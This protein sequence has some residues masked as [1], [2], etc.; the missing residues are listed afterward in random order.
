MASTIQS[1]GIGSGLDIASIVSSL[2]TAQGDAQTKQL[3]ARETDLKAQLSAYGTFRASLE[4]LQLRPGD[5]IHASA[6]A[7]DIEVYP[8]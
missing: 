3:T 8:A 7:T 2:T 5:E 6:K 4:A 1:T